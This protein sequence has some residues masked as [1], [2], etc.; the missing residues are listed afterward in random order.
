[1]T[2]TLPLLRPN[3]DLPFEVFD[4]TDPQLT[5][6]PSPFITT[7]WNYALQKSPQ[8]F[9][10][11]SI[12]GILTYGCR[13]GCA[14]PRTYI[15]SQNLPTC[16]LD[17]LSITKKLAEDICRQRVILHPPGQSPYIC[18]PIGL[19]EKHDGTYRRIHHL[20]FPRLHSV[21]DYI[22]KEYGALKYATF[23]AVLRRVLTAG[24]HC[25]IFKRDI[26]DAF[27]NIPVAIGDHW[28]LGFE[29]DGILYKE[30]CLPFGLRTAPAIFNLFAEALHWILQ[31]AT[32][33]SE[34]EHYL[35]DFM[36]I[37]PLIQATPLFIATLRYQYIA[38]TDFLG[39]PR[40]D[41]KNQEGQVVPIL[42]YEVDTNLLEARIPKEKLIHINKLC[43]KALE[44]PSI[45]LREVQK[46][47]GLLNFCSQVVQLGRVY[48][49]EIWNFV[50]SFPLNCPHQMKRRWSTAARKDIYWWHTLLPQY[51]GISFFGVER[52]E[53]YI[54]TDACKTGL[55]GLVF[56]G[57]EGCWKLAAPH[58]RLDQVFMASSDYIESEE[59]FDI[60]PLEVAAV[61]AA[62][63]K[64]AHL[65]HYFR[66][67]VVTD[68]TTTHTGLTK[69]TV[70]GAANAPLRKIMLIAA[71]LDIEITSRWLA[72]S[73]N[74]LADALSRFDISTVANLCPQLRDSISHLLPLAGAS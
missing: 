72:G 2:A 33:W 31:Y 20:S 11:S 5:E 19:V 56:N 64:W 29:W 62:F 53:V 25:L 10:R 45:S 23:Q 54:F 61:L 46:L 60:N 40:N 67:I 34:I 37:V 49:R 65:W 6:S 39:V 51:N 1:M 17:R 4:I 13:T 57:Y 22:N 35:D 9:L 15:V 52:S 66:V 32:N 44:K 71:E 74:T 70:R 50:G 24:R 48:M 28:L 14:S 63:R 55:G 12:T 47:A 26:K 16:E 42:G 69:D 41:A 43:A 68:N 18:S 36:L 30:T 21:N 73:Q 59:H 7:A 8:I 58:L 38:V 3:T 27:R